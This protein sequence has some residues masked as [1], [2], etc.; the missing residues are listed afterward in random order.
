MSKLKDE[1][2]KLTITVDNV[3]QKADVVHD[4]VIK[5]SAVFTAAKNAM[6]TITSA[7]VLKMT[8]RECLMPVK[9]VIDALELIKGIHPCVSVA[10]VA[11]QA[12]LALEMKRRENDR[13]VTG[14]LLKKADMMSALLQLGT[15][16][17][18]V[19]QAGVARFQKLMEDITNEITECGNL[20][21][22]F[23]KQKFLGKFLR[24][25]KWEEKLMNFADIFDKRKGDIKDALEIYVAL[26]L[27]SVSTHVE[28]V[29]F[30]MDALIALFKNQTDREKKA[31]LEVKKRGGE[32]NCLKDEAALAQL[33]MDTDTSGLT[34]STGRQKGKASTSLLLSIR[35]SIDALVDQNRAYFDVKIDALSKQLQDAIQKTTQEI[36]SK[37]G[38]GPW[39][40]VNDPDIKHVWKDMNARS[41]VKTRHLVLALHDY[42]IDLADQNVSHDLNINNNPQHE[43]TGVEVEPASPSEGARSS[44]ESVEK[45]KWCI[46]Y[47]SLARVPAIAEAIDDDVSGFIKVAEVN[48][49]YRAKPEGS[50]ML[51]WITFWAAGWGVEVT[52]YHQRIEALI[53]RLLDL[54]ILP[55]NSQL[56]VEYQD[57]LRWVPWLLRSHRL[58]TTDDSE[59]LAL[60]RQHMD[61]QEAAIIVALTPAKWEIDG[62]DTISTL[63]GPGRI[64]KHLYPLLYL[65]LKRHYQVF[66]LGCKTAL[67]SMEFES[68]SETIRSILFACG[69]RALMLKASCMQQ[70]VSFAD[71]LDQHAGGL[72]SRCYGVNLF[73]DSLDSLMTANDN[74]PL[75]FQTG[76]IDTE[77]NISEVNPKDLRYGVTPPFEE[78]ETH[79]QFIDLFKQYIIR[80]YGDVTDSEESNDADDQKMEEL[81]GSMTESEQDMC[82]EIARQENSKLGLQ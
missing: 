15:I 43:E 76:D 24:A 80:Q 57:V 23:S 49:F 41:S 4:A 35:S 44:M 1:P 36:I 54:I 16:A 55:E 70:S 45:D 59:L 39:T 25:G 56:Y 38:R 62:M 19:I 32:E 6:S 8:P 51:R 50:S 37:F 13:R 9:R 20:L 46:Q 69:L 61:Q 31:A 71:R 18:P 58:E 26:K 10:V 7:D 60:V 73:N 67:D 5:R 79:R 53:E 11:F 14:L 21:D 82:M 64:E 17:T 63:L 66:K 75:E 3:S 12:V 42:F 27:T 68:A 28:T 47:L 52:I 78:T 30:K 72:F 65:V 40:R 2:P 34:A 29:E 33:E 74:R 77:A 48:D 22:T 81:S